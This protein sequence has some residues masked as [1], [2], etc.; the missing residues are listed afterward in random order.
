MGGGGDRDRTSWIGRCAFAAT[1]ATLERV[2]PESGNSARK[3]WTLQ[4]LQHQSGLSGST[5]RIMFRAPTPLIQ[6]I[7][8]A[9]ETLDRTL[10]SHAKALAHVQAVVLARRAF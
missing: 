7:A 8:M 2:N 10:W 6:E 9:L 1:A 5:V 3:G 4:V